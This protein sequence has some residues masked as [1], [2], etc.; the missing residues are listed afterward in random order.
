MIMIVMFEALCFKAR[1]NGRVVKAIKCNG[2][3]F[4]HDITYYHSAIYGKVKMIADR[5]GEY[6]TSHYRLENRKQ[7]I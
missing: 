3:Y 6:E 4:L 2:R 7:T 5:G 1:E